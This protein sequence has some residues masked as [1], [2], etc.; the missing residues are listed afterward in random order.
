M[1]AELFLLSVFL[2]CCH[3]VVCR[4][5]C[6]EATNLFFTGLGPAF[7]LTSSLGKCFV[8]G[9]ADCIAYVLKR[10]DVSSKKGAPLYESGCVANRNLSCNV[11]YRTFTSIH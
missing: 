4:N 5:G 3:A 10:P 7:H 6:F 8:F 11:L 2:E 9:E 1:L